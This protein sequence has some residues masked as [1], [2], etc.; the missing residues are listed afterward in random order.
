MLND[1]DASG[2]KRCIWRWDYPQHIFILS[3]SFIP[4]NYCENTLKAE[5]NYYLIPQ[6]LANSSSSSS[7]SAV[8]DTSTLLFS[9][10]FSAFQLMEMR[11]YGSFEWKYVPVFGIQVQV[12]L[13]FDTV[14][15]PW[16]FGAYVDTALRK[17]RMIRSYF[18]AYLFSIL[19]TF[20]VDIADRFPLITV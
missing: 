3:F 11:I 19:S 1:A 12:Q 9:M 4:Y 13:H 16:F 8:S 20:P 5:D 14:H 17:S 7:H 6:I 15:K 10:A 18:S 2:F